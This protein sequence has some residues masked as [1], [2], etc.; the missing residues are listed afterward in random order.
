MSR[1]LID[2]SMRENESLRYFIDIHSADASNEITSVKI[3][4]DS[5]AKVL[6][7]VSM[8]NK[9]YESTLEYANTLNSMLDKRLSRG[10]MKKSD[11]NTYYNQDIDARCL[12]IE[13]GG[14][15]STKE[16]IENT[17]KFLAKI[18]YEFMSE[19]YDGN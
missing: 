6:F 19:G 16:E 11:A 9:F 1:T 18:L 15:E 17:I 5:Y 3:D 10:I 13:L 7:V 4:N 2:E 14:Y 12:M 8:E